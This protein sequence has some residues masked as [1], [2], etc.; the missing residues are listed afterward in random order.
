MYA[1]MVVERA[2]V[3]AL[4][5]RPRHPYTAGLFRSLPRLTEDGEALRPISGTVPDA[6]AFPAGC[7]FHPRCPHAMPVCSKE[8][9]PLVNRASTGAE[10]HLSAC[11]FVDEHP[12]ADLLAD[13]GEKASA[14]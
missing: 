10:P 12:E 6:T 7:R 14:P 9:P 5:E 8:T 1:G 3:G 4:F 13:T 11:F 2:T